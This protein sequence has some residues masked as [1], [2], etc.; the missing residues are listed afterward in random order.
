MGVFDATCFKYSC[1]GK[2]V[3][4]I[5]CLGEFGTRAADYPGHP[6]LQIVCSHTANLF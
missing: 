3:G 6:A 2:A 1:L 5:T 4:A